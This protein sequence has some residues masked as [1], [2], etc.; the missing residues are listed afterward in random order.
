MI[1][2]PVPHEPRTQERLPQSQQP[3]A[4]HPQNPS[5]RHPSSFPDAHRTHGNPENIEDGKDSRIGPRRRGLPVILK[6]G[7]S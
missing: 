5:D 3:H 7:L 2:H 6:S 4:C 1:P